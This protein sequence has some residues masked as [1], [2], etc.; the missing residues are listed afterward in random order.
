MNTYAITLD[1]VV[2]YQDGETGPKA[3]YAC[4]RRNRDV[5]GMDFFEFM[6]ATSVHIFRRGV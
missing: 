1:G 5:L 2:V 4:W 6:T 3:K